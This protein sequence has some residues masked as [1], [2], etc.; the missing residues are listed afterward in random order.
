MP[1]CTNCGAQYDDGAKFCPTCGA[2]TGET[3][4]QSTYTNAQQNTAY[5]NPTQWK[6]Q[7]MC[8]RETPK[9]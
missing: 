1:Y 9:I 2:T 6:C 7:E 3:A 5:T 4:Q 8:S